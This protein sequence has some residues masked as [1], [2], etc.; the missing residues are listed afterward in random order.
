MDIE[1]LKAVNG[2]IIR[3]L[4]DKSVSKGGIELNIGYSMNDQMPARY[5]A[6]EG[7]VI[8]AKPN[9][10][11]QKGD[12]LYYTWNALSF[13]NGCISMPKDENL[14]VIKHSFYAYKQNGQLY[15]ITD[16][17]YGNKEFGYLLLEPIEE[18]VEEKMTES[19]IILSGF[20]VQGHVG[21]AEVV[22]HK[23]KKKLHGRI[24]ILPKV[25][26]DGYEEL[27]IGE[28][29]VCEPTSDIVVEIEGKQYYRVRF[30]EI[31]STF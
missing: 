11:A 17:D 19:G 14:F 1:S 24:A 28:G 10:P 21:K 12:T 15:S 26:P 16:N 20:T 3:P 31:V 2:Y 8:S 22:E 9:A 4:W 6:T 23:T 30:S 13:V 29:I 5:W 7:E 18:K 27:N 25:V